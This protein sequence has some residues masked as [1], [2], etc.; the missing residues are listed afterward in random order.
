MSRD[1]FLAGAFVVGFGLLFCWHS[2]SSASLQVRL[3][4]LESENSALLRLVAAS[5][6][7]KAK[8]RRL[9]SPRQAAHIY[10]RPK[11]DIGELLTHVEPAFQEPCRQILTGEP[12]SFAQAWQA[13]SQD[14]ATEQSPCMPAAVL[15]VSTRACVLSPPRS[16]LSSAG[17][18]ALSQRLQAP[19]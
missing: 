19:P 8:G 17:L 12:V 16:Q 3:A 2:S 1:G 9:Q 15:L 5:T 11:V 10:A 18:V 14:A 13:S 6:P 4:E 7:R